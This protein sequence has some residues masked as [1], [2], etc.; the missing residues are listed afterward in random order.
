MLKAPGTKRSKL[1]YDELLSNHAFN[2]DLRRYNT[3]VVVALLAAKAEM[4]STD[5]D[6]DTPLHI[7]AENGHEQVVQALLEKGAA[8]NMVGWCRLSR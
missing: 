5:N 8:V 2:F 6:G 3:A 1:K 7:A 4:D